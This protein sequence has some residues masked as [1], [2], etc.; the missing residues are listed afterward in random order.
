MEKTWIL[1]K[2]DEGSHMPNEKLQVKRENELRIN[3]SQTKME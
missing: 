1:T 3:Q 2:M